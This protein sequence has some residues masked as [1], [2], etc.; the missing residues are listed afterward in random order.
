MLEFAAAAYDADGRLLNGMLNEGVVSLEADPSAK[1]GALFEG[2]QE[3]EVPSG[4]AWIRLAVR[5]KLN[6]RTG[7]LE[8]QLPLKG[9]PALHAVEQG[10]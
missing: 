8:L 6:D 5:D 1:S 2:M 10:R 9:D 4:G 3:L 7:T